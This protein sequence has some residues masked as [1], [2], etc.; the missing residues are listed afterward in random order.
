MQ[1][2]VVQCELDCT[3]QLIYV[4]ENCDQGVAARLADTA[5]APK[6]LLHGHGFPDKYLQSRAAVCIVLQFG[7]IECSS[8]TKSVLKSRKAWSGSWSRIVSSQNPG[9]QIFEHQS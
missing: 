4:C 6:F 9:I 5:G 1:C 2:K 7:E 3:K 8:F